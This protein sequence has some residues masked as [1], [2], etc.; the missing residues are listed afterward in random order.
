MNTSKYIP[1][2]LFSL[3]LSSS[4]VAMVT[5]NTVYPDAEIQPIEEHHSDKT[6]HDLLFAI[7]HQSEQA[8][9]NSNTNSLQSSENVTEQE[10]YGRY[11]SEKYHSWKASVYL[12]SL[13][14]TEI[15]LTVK[16]RIFPFH[17]YL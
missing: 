8:L 2:L 15:S 3:L 5:V 11:T 17:F 16:K 10:T 9:H 6:T 13:R 1:V 14:I 4:S 7:H 12:A